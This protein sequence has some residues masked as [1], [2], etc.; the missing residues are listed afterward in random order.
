M[1]FK[2]LSVATLIISSLC[3]SVASI[4]QQPSEK[5]PESPKHKGERIEKILNVMLVQALKAAALEMDKDHKVAPFAIVQ[6]SAGGLGFFTSIADEAHK[7][8]TVDQKTAS[9]RAILN[10]LARK[11]KINASVQ[12]MY[13]SIF[14]GETNKSSQGL[15]FEVEHRDGVSFMRFI[16]VVEVKDDAGNKTGKLQ[17]EME[18]LTTSSKPQTVFIASIV[19]VSTQ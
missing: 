19:Q 9:V 18:R 17:F 2:V 6:K 15:V 8:E 11:H 3:F 5:M 14:N 10:D 7:D 13:A 12:V 16:P 1:N 4:A